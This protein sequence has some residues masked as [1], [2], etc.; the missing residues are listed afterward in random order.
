VAF[1]RELLA[2]GEEVVS[3][4]RPNWTVLGWPLVS[5]VAAACLTVGVVI[6]FPKA[7]IAVL[8]LVLAVLVV[9]LSWLGARAVRRSATTIVVTTARVMRRTGVLS[10]TNLEIRLERINELSYHQSIAGR[11]L[12]EGEVLIEVGGETGVVVLD[13]VPRPAVVQSL[14]SGQVSDWHRRARA[15]SF[16]APLPVVDT[17]PAG[18][19]LAGS[20]AGGAPTAAERLVQLDELR[21]RGILSADEFEAKRAQLL[22]EL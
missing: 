18:T 12:R 6:A 4:F 19:T 21:R 9:A 16:G 13:H 14:I 10:R 15:P 17:P 20:G 11:L 2:D 5:S 1:P 8:Y 7:P 3:E 22:R